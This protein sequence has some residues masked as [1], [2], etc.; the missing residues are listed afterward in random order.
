MY[1]WG[2][3]GICG[4]CGTC[5]PEFMILGLGRRGLGGT[6]GSKG[7][8]SGIVVKKTSSPRSINMRATG[9][10]QYKRIN[11]PQQSSLK[12]TTW[13]LSRGPVSE[14]SRLVASFCPAAL[15]GSILI[16]TLD[17]QRGW[18]LL[19]W[20]DHC[21]FLKHIASELP[22]TQPTLPR[23]DAYSPAPMMSTQSCIW[24]HSAKF[25]LLFSQNSSDI[26]VKATHRT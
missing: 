24:V 11:V 4:T 2:I 10:G 26:M 17:A 22:T 13:Y 23:C 16:G 7:S 15:L 20:T 3:C 12:I 19:S 21:R 25:L 18:Y 8:Y 5:R 1:F 6:W 9:P 14:Y